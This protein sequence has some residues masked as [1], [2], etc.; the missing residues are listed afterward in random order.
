MESLA[1]LVMGFGVVLALIGIVL[2]ALKGAE[3]TSNVKMFGFE[4]QLGGSALVIFVMGTLIFLVPILY[5]EKFRDST[6]PSVKTDE[7]Y[8]SPPVA[9]T[10]DRT[11]LE[12]SST[13]EHPVKSAAIDTPGPQRSPS[14]LPTEIRALVAN[15][16]MVKPENIN[17][18]TPLKRQPIRCDDLDL[19]EILL[20]IEQRYAVD[21]DDEEVDLE[22]V[23][24]DALA[25]AVEKKLRAR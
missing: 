20:T 6:Q 8:S 23:S 3:G 1:Y 17:V 18:N 2:F 22:R 9:D 14:S 21:I 15:Q 5:E 12:A 24:I 16:L 7:R 25:R 11:R 19:I 10:A 4:F 13:P